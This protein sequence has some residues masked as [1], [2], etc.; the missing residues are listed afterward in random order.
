VRKIGRRGHSQPSLHHSARHEL[1][2]PEL[3]LGADAVGGEQAAHLREL[4]VD[5]SGAPVPE[6]RREVSIG[7]DRLVGDDRR[8]EGPCDF[9]HG[10]EVVRGARLLP[11][12]DGEAESFAAPAERD[13]F[14]GREPTVGVDAQTHAWHG[15]VNGLEGADVRVKL[16]ADLDLEDVKAEPL[17]SSCRARHVLG[18]GDGDRYVGLERGRMRAQAAAKERAKRY[19][20]DRGHRVE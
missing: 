11:A 16:G 13:G 19:L 3:R 5:A 10:I 8:V 4:E 12:F 1:E 7:L 9:G 18:V 15:V 17:P 6:H 2:S 20:G 14:A